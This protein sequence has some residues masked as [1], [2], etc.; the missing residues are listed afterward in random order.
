[1]PIE[2]IMVDDTLDFWDSYIREAVVTL[3]GQ[4]VAY[5]I[6]KTYRTANQL[7]K[8]VYMET[9]T[10]NVTDAWLVNNRGQRV[11]TKEVNFDK[12]EDGFMIIFVLD[13]SIHVAVQAVQTGQGG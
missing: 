12:K 1:M 13:L 2:K 7:Q 4:D 10:G 11:Q 5:P 6:F 3:N 8:L 9:E